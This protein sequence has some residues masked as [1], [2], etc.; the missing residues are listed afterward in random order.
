MERNRKGQLNASASM[1]R[2]DERFILQGWSRWAYK[3]RSTE[4]C[5]LPSFEHIA[6]HQYGTT[7][8]RVEGAVAAAAVAVAKKRKR[9]KRNV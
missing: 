1:L 8:S 6:T 7:S 2:L 5:L 4:F 3:K 9:E